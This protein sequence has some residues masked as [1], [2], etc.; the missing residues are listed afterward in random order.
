MASTS[1]TIRIVID[2]VSEG[3]RGAATQSAGELLRLKRSVDDAD[4]SVNRFGKTTLKTFASLGGIGSAIPAISG[5]ATSLAT[6]SGALL[7]LPGAA[8][9]AGIALGTLK[10]A[11]KGF[12]DAVSAA[13]PKE[14]AEATKNM[15]KEAVNTAKAVRLLKDPLEDLRKT[16]S[17]QFFTGLATDAKQLGGTYLPI[18]GRQIP[19]IAGDLGKMADA[20]AK[21]LLTPESVRAVNT[22]LG[23]TRQVTQDLAPALGNVVAGVLQIGAAGAREFNLFGLS[24]SSATLRFREW[25]TAANESGRIAELI[26][27]GREEFAKWGQ[28]LGN[29]GSIATTIFSGLKL[30]QTDFVANMIKATDAV[31]VFL[32][33]TTGQNG[34]ATF[35]QILATTAQVTRD[36]FLVAL[37]SVLPVIAASGP[38]I[39]EFAGIIGGTLTAAI[40][41]VG[42][43]LQALG[44]FMS[45]NVA[46]VQV[47]GPLILGLVVAFKG[48]S[49]LGSLVLPLAATVIA[50]NAVGLATGRLT[51]ALR[52]LSIA[53]G[54]IGI[55]IAGVTIAL[56]VFAAANLSSGD[57]VKVNQ[58][59]VES[60]KGTLDTYTGAVTAATRQQVAGELS[61]RTLSDGHTTLADAVRKTGI[62]LSDYTQAATGNQEVLAKV[63]RTL[64]DQA[65]AFIENDANLGRW[66][67]TV[68]DAHVPA[69]VLALAVIG[70]DE[71]LKSLT[72][73]YGISAGVAENLVTALKNQVGTLDEVG[74]ALG[75]YNAQLSEAQKQATAAADANRA[76]GQVLGALKDGLAG[77]AGG[78]GPLAVMVDGFKSLNASARDS[79][80][81]TGEAAQ[82]LGGVEAGARK[83]A[84]SMQESRDSFVQAAV[85]AGNTEEAANLLAD[86]I[87]LIPRVAD[88]AFRTNATD[89]ERDLLNLNVQIS[90]VPP[91]VPIKVE[92]LTDEAVK[93]LGDLGIYVT[94]LPNGEFE[95]TANTAK[96]KQN[97]ADVV[98]EVGRSTGTITVDANTKGADTKIKGSVSLADGSTGTMTLDANPNPATGKVGGVVKLADGSTGT[99]TLDGNRDP[100]TGKINATITYAN[101]STGTVQVQANTASAQAAIDKLKVTTYS[102][103][104]VR[105]LQTGEVTGRGVSGLAMG[106]L[107]RPMAAGGVLAMAAGGALSATRAT[108]VPPNTPRLI[109]DNLRV[110]EAFIPL[111]GSRR[112]FQ[113]L[114]QAARTL[115]VGVIP[116]A[117]GGLAGSSASGGHSDIVPEIRVFIGD[118][119]L[120][121]I[122]RTEISRADRATVRRARTGSGVTF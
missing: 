48:L 26:S 92:A 107:L 77:L 86:Q 82:Q 35:G 10:F 85:A 64:L 67:Q 50:M 102:T 104:I 66:K 81:S 57:A 65:T 21:A 5:L 61:T 69:E 3:L 42:P 46:V 7:V 74:S 113:I 11:T 75:A 72:D 45:E 119:E 100:A 89:A 116:M 36:V 121:G 13:D 120:T 97:L 68:D 98:N 33:S 111:D 112:S 24:V 6:A 62:S 90:R 79:A 109:G 8:L 17:N 78:G 19:L 60:I 122:I 22:V 108:V 43:P 1:S 49:I 114:Q 47:L 59:A 87:G 105:I 28:L 73:T 41:I 88:I 2:G 51:L 39:E 80:K 56:G 103:H 63:N 99:I 55:A 58:E 93:K 83:A 25:A 95:V 15:G 115:G 101:G 44:Q 18:L 94:K 20:S 40:Q 14:F 30:G 12:G 16:A 4:K 110:P 76:F 71:A 53:A 106:G 117:E 23:Q 27:R 118:T 9:G 52:I 91:G 34:L 31:R 29:V 32:A 96:A 37:Q 54:P 70:N 38:A 84:Q